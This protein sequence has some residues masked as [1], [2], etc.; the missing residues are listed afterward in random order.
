MARLVRVS[1]QEVPIDVRRRAA[2]RLIRELREDGGWKNL[3]ESI[4][5]EA[6]AVCPSSFR[7]F[8]SADAVDRVIAGSG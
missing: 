6:A 8:V 2:S 5:L 4:E 7:Y 1:L 3:Q